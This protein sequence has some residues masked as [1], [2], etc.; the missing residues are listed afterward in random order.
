MF[1]ASKCPFLRGYSLLGCAARCF[2]MPLLR[3]VLCL[4]ELFAWSYPLLRGVRYSVVF[5]LRIKLLWGKLGPDLT[6]CYM[7]VSIVE[8]FLLAEVT[9]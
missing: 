5:I 8:R 7:E 1:F 6:V 2:E 3:G 9:L 4:D